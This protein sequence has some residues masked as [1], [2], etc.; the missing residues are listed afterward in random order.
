MKAV[1][2]FIELNF[3]R[4]KELEDCKAADKAREME[5]KALTAEVLDL[6]SQQIS[7]DQELADLRQKHAKEGRL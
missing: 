1:Q 6:R 7:K 3:R 2:H 4:A 5:L